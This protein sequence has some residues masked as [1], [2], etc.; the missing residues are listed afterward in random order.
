MKAF[1][2]RNEKKVLQAAEVLMFFNTQVFV[3]EN[4]FFALFYFFKFY[5]KFV[6]YFFVNVG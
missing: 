2:S 4:L 6:K 5:R 3:V 1:E